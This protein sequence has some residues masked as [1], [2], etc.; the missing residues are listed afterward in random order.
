MIWALSL[1]TVKLCP[2]GLTAIHYH[3]GIRSLFG[4][5]TQKG[6]VNHSVLYPSHYYIALRLNAFRREPAITK[7]DKLFTSNHT[8]SHDIEQSMSSGLQCV[9]RRLSP[10]A[11]LARSGFGSYPNY[12]SNS[13][14]WTLVGL[15][16]LDYFLKAAKA[17]FK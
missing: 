5:P 1:A 3:E 10:W 17:R 11:W 12:F 16:R 4:R 6:T 8:S 7:L 2:H 15:S 14:F 9:F 13:N